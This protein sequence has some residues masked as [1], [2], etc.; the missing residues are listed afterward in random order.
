MY[1]IVT[2]KSGKSV[3]NGQGMIIVWQAF[4]FVWLV[5]QKSNLFEFV[6]IWFSKTQGHEW[7]DVSAALGLF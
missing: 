1:L 5:F 6:M 7:T 3:H 4:Y 2:V